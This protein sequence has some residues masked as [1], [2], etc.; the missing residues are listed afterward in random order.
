MTT[1]TQI[2]GARG[3]VTVHHWPATE[4]RYILLLAHGY[5]EHVGRYADFAEAIAADGGVVYAPDHHGHGL[6]DGDR[7]LVSIDDAVSDLKLVAERARAEHS[8]LPVVLLGHSMGGIVA[9]RFAQ[10]L[11]HE[12]AALIL[13]GP[14][15]G[16]NA[17]VEA[18]LRFDPIP[19]VPVDPAILSR[20]PSV[21]E[22]YAADPLVYHGPFKKATLDAFVEANRAIADG[23][24]LTT[25]PVLWIHGQDDALAPLVVS[26]AAVRRLSGG[27]A[28]EHVYPH[29]L[30]E[31]L[32]ERNRDQVLDDVLSFLD[33]T[34][35][36]CRGEQHE[37]RVPAQY[38]RM[39]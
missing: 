20:D 5:G 15:I 14:A 39:A 17:G 1:R 26:M 13:S 4:P 3:R 16:R 33:R 34:T 23:P 36:I 25:L 19:D 30:H 31:V 29:A 6:S 12:L 11:Q 18:L 37:P 9:A 2:D 22:A 7:A 8:R 38:R 24:V 21:G 27:R 35:A 28:E 32:N 10:L